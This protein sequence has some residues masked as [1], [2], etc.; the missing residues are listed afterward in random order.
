LNIIVAGKW[1]KP[2][3]MLLKK[4]IAREW[5][6]LCLVAVAAGAI[7]VLTSYNAYLR[8]EKDFY[9]L[10]YYRIIE[11]PEAFLDILPQKDKEIY[12]RYIINYKSSKKIPLT[13]TEKT[14]LAKTTTSES[15]LDVLDIPGIIVIGT[16]AGDLSKDVLSNLVAH[17]YFGKPTPFITY[18]RNN[19]SLPTFLKTLLGVLI[20]VSTLRLTSWALRI[21]IT[22]S[23]TPKK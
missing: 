22:S 13:E 5:L 23:K 20:V 19:I 2:H 6:I 18:A 10:N 21:V 3:F 17:G 9:A 4:V 12:L 7:S 14:F 15:L 16:Q 1:K 8:S 11:E